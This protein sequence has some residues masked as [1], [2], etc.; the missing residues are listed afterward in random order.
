[1]L[2][3]SSFTIVC[4]CGCNRVLQKSQKDVTELWQ[5]LFDGHSLDG[6]IRRGGEAKYEVIDGTIKG[7]TVLNT[8]NSFLCTRQHYS[9]FILEFEFLVDPQLNS[10][11]QIRSNSFP[12]YRNGRIHGYQVEIDPSQS[13]YDAT[14]GPNYQQDGSEAPNT[15][16]RSWTGGIYDEAGR[17]WLYPLKHNPKARKA[18]KPGQWNHTRIEAVGDT[19]KTWINNVP[20]AH[21]VDTT[22]H[23]GFIALQVHGIGKQKEKEGIFVQW[24]NIRILTDNVSNH[25]RQTPLPA[26]NMFNKLTSNEKK[27][28]WSLLWDGQTT[29]G[30][31]SAKLERFPAAGWIIED[32]MLTVLES[33]GSESRAGGDIVT[34]D[35]YT[36]FELCVDFKI[37]PGANSGIK[38]F[39]DTELNKGEGSAIGLEYQILD[40]ERHEDARHGA[41]PG[42]RTLASLY[43]LI[44]AENKHPNPIGEWNHARIISNNQH[45]EHWLNGRK[46]LEYERKSPAYRKLVSESKYEKWPAFGE[47]PEGQ[48]LLQDHGNRVSFR[49]IKI[50]VLK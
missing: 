42:S 22:T 18:F 34:M 25:V 41:Q 31:R 12:E 15:E 7:T 8:S 38:Y 49:N 26:Q 29:N 45:V 36:N 11:V 27:G 44:K 5:P 32:D 39:V 13:P 6:W 50:K 35:K 47:L 33:G 40:D 28:G 48:I 14:H 9:D 24:R 37:T 2:C 10:G 3:V 23:D 20:T 17:G 1:M 4:L 30:W 16:P 19:I 46:V 43:D 21:L